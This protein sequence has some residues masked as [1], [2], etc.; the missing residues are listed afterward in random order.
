MWIVC[1]TLLWCVVA[2]LVVHGHVRYIMQPCG[3]VFSG[4]G[5]LAGSKESMG[6]ADQ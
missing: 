5:M 3:A 6:T 2:C 4:P 1:E